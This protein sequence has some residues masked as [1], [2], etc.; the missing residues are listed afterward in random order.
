MPPINESDCITLPVIKAGRVV[1][2]GDI[3]FK[4]DVIT[5]T[6]IPVILASAS[7]TYFNRLGCSIS[8]G[9]ATTSRT[10]A[11]FMFV[12]G[13]KDG[14]FSIPLN[15]VNPIVGGGAGKTARGQNYYSAIPEARLV[16]QMPS[17][18]S[19]GS[20]PSIVPPAACNSPARS[21]AARNA[22]N[23]AAS[24]AGGSGNRLIG[25]APSGNSALVHSAQSI[26][27]RC[28]LPEPQKPLIQTAFCVP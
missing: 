9:V 27:A 21:D 25:V 17:V 28:D 15:N 16:A 13:A 11:S 10:A 19:A 7:N 12:A 8:H 24:S 2:Y 26:F 20:S 22:R 5:P 18:T 3:P 1:N 23:S 4:G 6:C 14:L